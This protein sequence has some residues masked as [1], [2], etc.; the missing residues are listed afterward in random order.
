MALD[1][2]ALLVVDDHEDNLYTLTLRLRRLGYENLTTAVDGVQALERIGEQRFDAVFLDIMMPRKSGYQ[3][4]EELREQGKLADL[5]VIMISAI[6]DMDSVAR[7]IEL[8]AEDYLPKPFNPTLL[9]ARLK[10]TLEKKALRD[11][12]AQQLGIIREVFGKYVPADVAKAIV[13]GRGRL[14]PTLTKAT[15]LYADIERFTDLSESIGPERMVG[16]LNE[17]FPAM[18]EPVDRYGG[19][20]SQ[21]QGDALLVT[22]N[23]PAEDPAHADHA[24]HV[25]RSMLDIVSQRRFAGERLGIR[26]GINTGLVVAGNVG[27][28]ERVSYTVHGDAVNVAARLEKLNKELRTRLL[29]S[30]STVDAL[31]EAH[32][33]VPVGEFAIRGKSI[34]TPVFRLGG[35]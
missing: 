8:G 22:F 26:V 12:V 7:C 28:G 31:K 5:P 11:A 15:V 24:V 27:S 13:D 23:V 35:P 25:A 10:A 14:A 32:P 2:P 33:L 17:Y 30:G 20:V 3:V 1:S 9:K 6:D 34:V 29:V 4:L 18:M 16:V 21:F 19:V